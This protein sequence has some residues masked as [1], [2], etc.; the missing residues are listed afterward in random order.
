M[1][2]YIMLVAIAIASLLLLVYFNYS[3]NIKLLLQLS[4]RL[5]ENWR[6]KGDGQ[7]QES[8]DH[9]PVYFRKPYPLHHR[10]IYWFV[11]G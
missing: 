5:K 2:G 6:A 9:F 8:Q 1:A 4:G 10:C 7:Q 3:M 11:F